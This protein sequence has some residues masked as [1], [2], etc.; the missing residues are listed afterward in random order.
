MGKQ[1]EHL[2]QAI[3]CL[4]RP[5]PMKAPAGL[6]ACLAK[7]MKA[8]C[9]EPYFAILAP[10]PDDNTFSS[11]DGYI[12]RIRDIDQ[13]IFKG[14]RRVYLYNSP[15]WNCRRLGFYAPVPDEACYVIYNDKDPR[16]LEYAAQLI[17]QSAG[18]YIHSV[19]RLIP[20]M[21]PEIIGDTRPLFD[22]ASIP[23]RKIIDLHGL[24]S[25]ELDMLGEPEAAVRLAEKAEAMAVRDADLCVAVTHHMIAEFEA[26][27]RM[28]IPHSLVLPISIPAEEYRMNISKKKKAISK[29]VYCGGVQKWQRVEDMLDAVNQSKAE[30]TEYAFYVND[31]EVFARKLAERVIRKPLTYGTKTGN[32]LK[33]VLAD[34]DFGFLLRDDSP[35][36]RV[37]CPTKLTEYILS[38]IIPILDFEDIGDLKS[39]GIRY[40]SLDD[41]LEGR[42]P[43]DNQREEIIQSNLLAVKGIA[44]EREHSLDQLRSFMEDRVILRPAAE[45]S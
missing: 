5:G 4:L 19:Y 41:F 37:A 23:C 42:L 45:E 26:K 35:V 25:A 1:T 14:K 21:M 28:P 18:C 13:H 12:Q 2:K 9:E 30:K 40:V 29:I 38:G 27:Y 10:W 3:M 33:D 39:L 36:N 11:G 34:A 16:Q 43:D 17:R 6:P 15:F 32:D 44:N 20:C 24:V 8:F 31:E 22:L 7:S